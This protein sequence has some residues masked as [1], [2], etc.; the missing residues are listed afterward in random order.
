MVRNIFLFGVC[1][2]ILFGARV[3]VD[4]VILEPFYFKLFKAGVLSAPRLLGFIP[5]TVLA[6]FLAAAAILFIL[7]FSRRPFLAALAAALLS[8]FL[9]HL[10]QGNL[11][12]LPSMIVNAWASTSFLGAL[13]A[14]FVVDWLTPGASLRPISE[15]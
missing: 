1:L 4:A 8:F 5:L 9:A 14:S 2:L 15:L 3:W 12:Q 11:F 6:D 13:A 10:G 7:D